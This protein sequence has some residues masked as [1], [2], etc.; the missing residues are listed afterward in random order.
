MYL[1]LQAAAKTRGLLFASNA[2]FIGPSLPQLRTLCLPRGA[3]HRDG[4]VPILQIARIA[5]LPCMQFALFPAF[6]L[7]NT[8]KGCESE[9]QYAVT[10]AASQPKGVVLAC[11]RCAASTR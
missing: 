9:V 4:D 5:F 7:L 3:V 2:R 8:N 1:F 6:A 10:E 11:F